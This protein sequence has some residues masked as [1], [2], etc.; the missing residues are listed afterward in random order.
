ML[1]EEFYAYV[2]DV[3]D[4]LIDAFNRRDWGLIG[5]VLD[6]LNKELEKGEPVSEEFAWVAGTLASSETQNE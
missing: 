5:G 6:K 2:C 4:E 3:T 1:L